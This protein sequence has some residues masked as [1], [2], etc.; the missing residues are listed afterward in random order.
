LRAGDTSHRRRAIPDLLIM[1]PLKPGR[2]NRLTSK[3]SR[4]GYR[5]S[6]V[7]R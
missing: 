5:S 2:A 4:A 7:I 1:C 3:F 6:F